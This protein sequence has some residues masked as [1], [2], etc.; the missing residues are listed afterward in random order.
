MWSSILKKSIDLIQMN[1]LVAYVTPVGKE[2]GLGGH[3]L[4]YSGAHCAQWA[5]ICHLDIEDAWTPNCSNLITQLLHSGNFHLTSRGSKI[6]KY[7]WFSVCLLDVHLS[8]RTSGLRYWGKTKKQ[9]M[10]CLVAV[11]CKE[12]P[13]NFNTTILMHSLFYFR[14][15]ILFVH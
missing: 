2:G 9:G 5:E 11:S 7:D 4:N 6:N 8:Q 15:N 1:F 3:F 12:S 14:L 13:F 10:T